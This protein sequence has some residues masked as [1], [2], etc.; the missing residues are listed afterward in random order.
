MDEDRKHL[1]MDEDRKHPVMGVANKNTVAVCRE[2]LTS[3]VVN[4]F[5][6]EDVAMKVEVAMAAGTEA[7]AVVMEA[8][9]V[10]AMVAAVNKNLAAVACLEA[11][12]IQLAKAIN[13]DD[14]ATMMTT[15]MGA[16]RVEVATGV[17]TEA[18]IAG[19]AATTVVTEAET[20]KS[21]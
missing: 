14:V 10:A 19:M 5:R 2:D 15:S 21:P 7:A 11:L 4:G 16:V 20:T 9:T 18:A 8:T 12:M 17:V 1:V 6:K 3:Q 13:K